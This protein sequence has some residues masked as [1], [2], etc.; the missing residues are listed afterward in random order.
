L[1]KEIENSALRTGVLLFILLSAGPFPLP[2]RTMYVS[3]TGDDSAPCAPGA[4]FRT[5][6]RA[7][8]CLAPGDT[9]IVRDGVYEGGVWI[10]IEAYA[11]A[12]V[13]IRGES[14]EAVI[15]SSGPELDC[16]RVQDAAYITIDRL[17]M[18]RASRAGCAVRFS[19]H[20]RLTRCRMADNRTWGVFTSF[21][22]D[23]HFEG[24]E[25]YGS[26][27][28]HGIYHSNSGDRFVI[29]GNL[30]HDNH[31]NGIH[32]NGD[33]EMGGDGVLNWGVV[34]K[35]IIYGNGL[36]G[37][38][39]INMTHVHDV[40]V[41]NNLIYN[42]YAAGM[43]VYQDTGTFEQGSKRVVIM[44]NTVYFQIY[45]GRCCVNVQTTSEKVLL[46]GNIFISGKNRGAIQVD[47]DHLSSIVSDYNI[48]GGAAADMIVERKGKKV[49]F[50]GW[51]I[52]TGNDSHSTVADPRFA[53]LDSADFRLDSISPAIDAGMPL[54]TVRADLEHLGGFEW[55]L[56][57][58]DSLPD[59][60][61][62]GK[63]RPVGKGPDAGAYES[64]VSLDFNRDGSFSP[65]DA[66]A[67]VLLA[68]D[69]PESSNLDLNGD[70]RYSIIDVV[71]LLLLLLK[72]V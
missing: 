70:G 46:A 19:H 44:G 25:C 31:G 32:L 68:I 65:A 26:R 42:N 17:T 13:L 69:N 54:D 15:D 35:N 63:W 34:E 71:Y 10:Q 29:R 3:P 6:K 52:L 8:A 59:E 20:I 53:S 36:G 55:I 61:L 2:G 38:A 23:I 24:N 56:A 14:L 67:L 4:E 39:G 51:R 57:Q 72:P 28:E 49:S 30:V 37:G 64:G 48:L 45:Q 27:D 50:E 58:L 11:E 41:R 66:V 7:V 60:D 43:T 18:R 33:P 12:P 40:L 22:N 62:T 16:I 5:L 9:L 1:K 47:S 21:A